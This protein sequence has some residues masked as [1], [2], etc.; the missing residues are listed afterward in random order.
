[1][2]TVKYRISTRV[3]NGQ[4]EVL[5]RFYSGTFGQRAKTHIPVPV[6]AWDDDAGALIVPKKLTP[7]SIALRE[8]QHQLDALADGILDA[9]WRE[10]Y[11]A[12]DGWLQRTIDNLSGIARE[13]KRMRMTV[14]ECVRE[15]MDEKNLEPDTKRHYNV[16]IGDIE[17][18][19]KKHGAP[20]AE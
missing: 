10:Q 2:P 9:W 17:R 11:D 14:C 15:Y 6:D 13:K 12:G 4:A 18:F 20:A 19:E 5:A 8:K 1:M 7:D 16:L 3:S